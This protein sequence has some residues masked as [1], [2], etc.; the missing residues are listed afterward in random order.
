[1]YIAV[2]RRTGAG[3]KTWYLSRSGL[4]CFRD[5]AEIVTFVNV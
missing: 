3:I 2:G 5:L 1:M 4:F